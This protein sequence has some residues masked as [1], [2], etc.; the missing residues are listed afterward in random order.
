MPFLVATV[1]L[2]GVLSV[3]NLLFTT[4]VVRRLREHTKLLDAVYELAADGGLGT[5]PGNFPAL[6]EAIGEFF[7]TTVDGTSVSRESLLDS[8]MVGF[9]SPTCRGCR[10]QLPALLEWAQGRDRERVLVVIDGRGESPDELVEAL[11]P[12][13]M[14]VV[15]GA[16]TPIGHAFK[17]GS[18]PG[19]CLLGTGGEVRAVAG[20]VKQLPVAAAA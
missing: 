7:A 9:L 1:I 15:E 6:G 10:E 11:R 17:V 14:V 8:T 5:T 18:V 12:V 4:G 3:L 19:F 2:V 13:A 16:D 20:Q